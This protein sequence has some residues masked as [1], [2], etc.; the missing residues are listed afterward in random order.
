MNAAAEEALVVRSRL[1]RRCAPVCE[2]PSFF[3]EA[4]VQQLAI[5]IIELQ[6]RGPPA[7]SHE[8]SDDL[9][10]DGH[11]VDELE[12]DKE[13]EGTMIARTDTRI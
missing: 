12:R 10:Q 9:N 2:V 1:H 11:E 7:I 8:K 4:R 5:V 3:R 6:V 13:D